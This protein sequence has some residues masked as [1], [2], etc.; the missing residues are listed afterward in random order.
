MADDIR[1]DAQRIAVVLL[2]GAAIRADRGRASTAAE[3]RHPCSAGRDHARE[4]FYP[5]ENLFVHGQSGIGPPRPAFEVAAR[6]EIE[7]GDQDA[8]DLV[9]QVDGIRVVQRAEE[10]A[11]SHEK[12]EAHGDLKHDESR[13]HPRRAGAGRNGASLCAQ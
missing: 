6:L 4:R 9:A 8:I 2:D 11:G 10:K 3:D 12:H 1:A 5:G 13:A 7:R